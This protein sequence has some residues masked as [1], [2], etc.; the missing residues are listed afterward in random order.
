MAEQ[1]PETT[2]TPPATEVTTPPVTITPPVTTEQGTVGATPAPA[3]SKKEGEQTTPVTPA[4]QPTKLPPE[5]VQKRV[6]RMYARLQEERKKRL[7]AEAF[8]RQ[9]TTTTGEEEEEGE[10]KP[11][12]TLTEADVEA[13]LE[14]KEVEKRFISSEVRVF[15]QHPDALNEDGSFNMSDIFVKKYI[16]IGRRNPMLA[17][18]ENGPELAAAMADKEL[19]SDFKKGRTVEATRLANQG[20]SNFTTTSTTTVPPNISEVQL[21]EVQKK[22]ARRMNM[23]DKEYADNQGSNKVKQKSWETKR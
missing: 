23:S 4:V 22:I 19:G 1:T 13:V 16:E 14:R 20:V 9:P 15:E 11:A 2:Q 7:A 18:M 21:T 3:P 8:T 5:E 12:S 10:T 6:D 17:A